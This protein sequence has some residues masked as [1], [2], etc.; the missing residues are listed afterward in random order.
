MEGCS[1]ALLL[2]NPSDIVGARLNI[3]D[4]SNLPWQGSFRSELQRAS[5]TN[6]RYQRSTIAIPWTSTSF[7]FAVRLSLYLG[8]ADSQ[9]QAAAS[10][11]AIGS[12]KNHANDEDGTNCTAG[13]KDQSLNL[14]LSMS[15]TVA[16]L[17]SQIAAEHQVA[18]EEV[19]LVA[20]DAMSRQLV[21]FSHEPD[22]A[23]KY[24]VA[25]LVKPGDTVNFQIGC[26]TGVGP[27]ISIGPAASELTVVEIDTYKISTCLLTF[28][29][30]SPLPTCLNPLQRS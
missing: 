21:Q 22:E 14:K 29:C 13:P 23:N 25:R 20:D 17:R 24:P 3:A 6:N 26:D 16:Q 19:F 5:R 18:P 10:S 9:Q 28:R 12:Q 8:T 11:T 1:P 15:E 30:S 27:F 7:V 4:L 2:A